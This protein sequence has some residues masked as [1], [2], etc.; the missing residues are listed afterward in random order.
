MV[1]IGHG[2]AAGQRRGL[3]KGMQLFAL[4]WG[5]LGAIG[6]KIHRGDRRQSDRQPSVLGIMSTFGGGGGG[7]SDAS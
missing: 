2:T 6:G 7:G 5:R 4:G 1:V 3:Q